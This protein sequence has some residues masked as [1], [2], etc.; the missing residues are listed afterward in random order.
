MRNMLTKQDIQ[1]ISDLLDK[2][3]EEK[4]E[5]KL[6]KKLKP[7]W[8]ELRKLRKNL[9]ITIST[10]DKDICDLKRRTSYLEEC[11]GFSSVN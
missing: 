2:N 10:F 4:L 3:L 6:E 9:N 8:K 5:E 7:I 11:E 1:T